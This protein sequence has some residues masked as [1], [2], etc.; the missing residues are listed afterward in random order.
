MQA[1]N[2]MRHDM[3]RIQARGR[4][5]REELER[6]RYSLREFGDF[7]GVKSPS[8]VRSIVLGVSAGSADVQKRIDDFLAAV[9]PT[10]GCQCPP[11]RKSR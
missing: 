2:V 1:I 5:L 3:N 7:I 4:D 11:R 10:C 8:H 6:R 9:C